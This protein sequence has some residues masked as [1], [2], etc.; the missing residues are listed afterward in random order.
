MLRSDADAEVI[1]VG[2]GPVGMGL[3]IELGQRGVKTIVIERHPTPQPVPKG[4][5]L[6]QRTMEHMHAWGAEPALRAARTIPAEAGIGGL[7]AYGS[8]L[9]GYHYDWL[10]RGLVNQYYSQTNE[11]LPQY[12]TEAVLRARAAELPSVDIR[13]G[14]KVT[15]AASDGD[16]IR[17]T[18]DHAE[19][20]TLAA[21]YVVGCDGSRSVVREAAGITQTLSD[22]DRVMVLLVFK[23]PELSEL[24]TRFPGK[25]YFN[26]LHPSQKGYWLFLG[27]VDLH[28]RWFFHAPVPTHAR[29]GGFD[30]AALLHDAVG[31]PFGFEMEHVGFWDLRFATAN[32][33]GRGGMFVAGDA[34]HSH[35]PYG[36][37]GINTGFEDA[38]N[39]GWKLAATL[40]GWGG[41]DLLASY[42]AERHAV[43]ASTAKDFIEKSIIDDRDFL[44]TFDPA[45]DPDGFASA[46]AERAV[47]AADEVD[48]FEPN[49]AGSPVVCD[50]TAGRSSAVGH[51]SFTAAAG[52]HLAPGLLLSGAR[53][54]DA[55][56]N[57]FTL[58]SLGADGAAHIALSR[59]AAESGIPL[60]IV[61]ET[62]PALAAH[63][64]ADLILIRPD[65]F[66][67]WAGNGAPDDVAKLLRRCAGFA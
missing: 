35:P 43:F 55:L 31:M 64:G 39:L 52:H 6:T 26:V 2:G 42:H 14:G 59:A 51:H 4:Q 24:L 60:T 9:S 50:M 40:Q 18:I 21:R 20:K 48:R 33:Y 5:N 22:H 57:D 62:N 16:L 61:S 7:T 34:A 46:W 15:Q 3:A 29:D 38:R 36:G 25:S 65:G 41:P 66:V 53:V 13:Y 44:E 32:A 47:G 12:A 11:R 30:F 37:Y 19:E 27:R 58:L 8:L 1:V 54:H 45:I 28:D 63:Y 23:S 49:Y 56:G 67:A 10:K 17:V